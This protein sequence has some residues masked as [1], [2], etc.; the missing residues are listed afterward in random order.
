[1]FG[2]VL[3]KINLYDHQIQIP[4]Y[5]DAILIECAHAVFEN[6]VIRFCD[7]FQFLNLTKNDINWEQVFSRLI[8]YKFPAVGYL[9]LIIINHIANDFFSTKPIPE[10]L[11]L[12]LKTKLPKSEQIFCINPMLKQLTSCVSMPIQIKL[13]TAAILFL[14]YNK[15]IGLKKFF[16][17]VNVLLTSTKIRIKNS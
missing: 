15:R 6:R 13:S 3:K 2:N 1:M 10:K 16:W 11:L 17:A 8:H 5:E 12:E 9:Y 4:S 14:T 7:L